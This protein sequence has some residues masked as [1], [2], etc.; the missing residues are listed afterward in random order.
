MLVQHN[1]SLA[2]HIDMVRL[3][4]QQ[5]NIDIHKNPDGY[6]AIGMATKGNLTEIVQLLKNAG[7]K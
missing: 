2:G 7:A 4:L 5:P 6:S 3:L 1:H